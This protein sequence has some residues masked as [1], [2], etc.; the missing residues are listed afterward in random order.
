MECFAKGKARR[1]SL[2]VTHIQGRE[3]K[4]HTKYAPSKPERLVVVFGEDAGNSNIAGDNVGRYVLDQL[5]EVRICGLGVRMRVLSGQPW[6][7]RTEHIVLLSFNWIDLV[8]ESTRK[9]A[10]FQTS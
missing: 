7:K 8:G 4:Q 3:S 2:S 10:R 1:V 5:L 6:Y 9:M